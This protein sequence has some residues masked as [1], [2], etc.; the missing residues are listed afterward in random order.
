MKWIKLYEE[1]LIEVENKV[2]LENAVY[3]DPSGVYHIHGW[4]NY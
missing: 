3:L 1:F 2:D 4:N